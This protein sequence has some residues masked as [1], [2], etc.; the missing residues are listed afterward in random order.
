M[1]HKVVLKVNLLTAMTFKSLE[2]VQSDEIKQIYG[3]NYSNVEDGFIF[4]LLQ[5]S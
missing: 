4:S 5:K 3:E 2:S 1:Q